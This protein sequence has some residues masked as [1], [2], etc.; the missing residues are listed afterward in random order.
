[1]VLLGLL[2]AAYVPALFHEVWTGREVMFGWRTEAW[3]YVSAV[4]WLAWFVVGFAAWGA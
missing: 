1:M 2:G 3:L 4:A